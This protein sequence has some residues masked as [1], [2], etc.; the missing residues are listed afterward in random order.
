MW[1]TN[2]ANFNKFY[3][4]QFIADVT[5]TLTNFTPFVTSSS[6]TGATTAGIAASDLTVENCVAIGGYYGIVINGPTTASG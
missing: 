4:C 5:S 2:A 6:A 3:G 1:L